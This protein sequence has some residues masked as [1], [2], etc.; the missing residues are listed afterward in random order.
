MAAI[1][2][3]YLSLPL[4][5][6]FLHCY[7]Q[8]GIVNLGS[9]IVAGSNH[10]WVSPSGEFA[11]GFHEITPDRYLVG[12]VF[13]KIPERTLV[14]SAN[15]DN[16]ANAKST[17][18][19]GPTGEFALIHANDTKVS[20]YDGT[21][22]TSAFMSD[23]G[24]FQL[25]NSSSDPIWQSF[26]HPTDTLLPGQVL[27]QGPSTVLKWTE[28]PT[29]SKGRFM[30]DFLSREEY[31]GSQDAN[32]QAIV[33]S[34]ATNGHSLLFDDRSG[35]NATAHTLCIYLDIESDLPKQ[36]PAT[37]LMIGDYMRLADELLSE[38]QFQAV[39]WTVGSRLQGSVCL[40]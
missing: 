35:I 14:W 7:A 8:N 15:R 12:I 24:N 13:D 29:I 11:F 10:F 18:I 27:S 36:P 39:V 5:L 31:H 28:K 19:F 38:E 40:A 20:I 4:L 34:R 17:I 9:S 33:H 1:K 30:L 23:D 22:T 3:L 32:L 21:D 25:L 37:K 16:P 26:D 6:C 2:L